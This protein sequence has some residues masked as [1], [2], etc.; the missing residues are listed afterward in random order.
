[1]ENRIKNL[2]QTKNVTRK[3]ASILKIYP[4]R[5]GVAIWVMIRFF[6]SIRCELNEF[7]FEKIDSFNKWVNL[8]RFAN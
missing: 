6:D 3:L 7:G 1:M 8:I 4:N 2:T 5:L